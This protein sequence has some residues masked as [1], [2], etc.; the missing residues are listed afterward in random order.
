VALFPFLAKDK[1]I[2]SMSTSDEN[3]SIRLEST[4]SH[5]SSVEVLNQLQ[6]S[7]KKEEI[8]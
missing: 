4:V 1:I 3:R 8:K 6:K 2:I 7:V 5:N